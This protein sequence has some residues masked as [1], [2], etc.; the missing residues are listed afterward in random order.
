MRIFVLEWVT[1]GGCLGA[2][3]P[4]SLVREGT[5]MRD[6]LVLDLIALRDVQVSIALD[7]RLPSP[8]LPAE[9]HRIKANP[10]ERWLELA[11]DADACLPVAPEGESGVVELYRALASQPSDLLGCRP[12]AV[13]LSADKYA[14]N[15]VL[16]QRDIPVPDTRLASARPPASETGWVVKPRR[17]AGCLDTRH[18]Q[19]DR[20][21]RVVSEPEAW[22]VEPWIEGAHASSCLLCAAGEAWLLTCNRQDVHET[23]GSLHY[24]GTLVAGLE[25]RRSEF[26]RLSDQIAGA[27]PGLWGLV[28]VDLVDT[29]TG[30]VVI[31]INP[32]PTTA[33]VG[34]GRALG[35]NPMSLLLAL[36]HRPLCELVRPLA[37]SPVQVRIDG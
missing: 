36:T 28:G 10:T 26:A 22:V 33:Y 7:A 25:H 32:R 14:A 35:L 31:E 17:G 30:P 24:T 19:A 11:E 13:A 37:P 6:R 20:A 18:L 1:G 21:P 3:L 29:V 16:R 27:V 8:D 5:A 23:A 2:D 34:L 4:P 15:A 12:D 9:V